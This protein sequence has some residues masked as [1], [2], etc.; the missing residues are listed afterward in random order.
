MTE[1]RRRSEP[2]RCAERPLLV[3][4]CALLWS[5]CTAGDARPALG[6]LRSPLSAGAIVETKITGSDTTAGSAFG[7]G[8][9]I[10]GNTALV[11]SRSYGA[12]L[13]SYQSGS[14][15]DRKLSFG[16]VDSRAVAIDGD[17]AL[18]GIY[19]KGA[20]VYE[21]SAGSWAPTA[22]LFPPPTSGAGQP[23]AL[24]R[25]TA[26][27]G[28][29]YDSTYG[30]GSGA[31]YV[32]KRN[33]STSWTKQA[34][35]VAK[36]G[37]SSDH[38]GESVDISGDT[39]IVGA[40]YKKTANGNAG[41]AYIF[42]RQGS[43]WTQQAKLV[44]KDPAASH[45]FGYSVAISGDTAVVGAYGDSVRGTYAGAAYVFT[46]TAGRW[47][48]VQKL[49][50]SDAAANEVFGEGVAI[51]GDTVLVCSPSAYPPKGYLFT[52]S[53]G[54]PF[55]EQAKLTPNAANGSYFGRALSLD[56]GQAIVGAYWDNAKG[57]SSGSA[58]V[59]RWK[60]QA[61]GDAG[62]SIASDGGVT[63]SDGGSLPGDAGSSK[64]DASS[65]ASIDA[66]GA[67]G[68][69]DA[70]APRGEHESSG[71][72]EVG[73]SGGDASVFWLLVLLLGARRRQFRRV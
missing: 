11:A 2:A 5:A 68:A 59:Y 7:T 32:Y 31:A 42:V 29:T 19:S 8:V 58:F 47:T 57:R 23:L 44:P 62:G 39:V 26:V 16:K 53:N 27:L 30:T 49:Y 67:R 70:A 14:W 33:S 50:A 63:D 6:R 43:S 55:S 40:S 35:L 65:P 64:G 18:V 10:D 36:D 54:G 52:R 24:D 13:F 45:R 46:R 20:T 73:S 37:V 21:R 66:G 51:D 69:P 17:I 48:Q 15:K 72:C 12:Y 1:L 38:L 56:D 4:A 3:A 61:G 71:G 60:P 34:K 25:A 41:T 9:A 28:A 22:N